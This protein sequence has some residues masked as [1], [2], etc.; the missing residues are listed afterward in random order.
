MITALTAAV[1]ESES[2]E[3]GTTGESLKGTSGESPGVSVGVYVMV[4]VIL[5]V[6]FGFYLHKWLEHARTFLRKRCQK[7]NCETQTDIESQH[8][9]PFL[10]MAPSAPPMTEMAGP[11]LRAPLRSG[12]G[13]MG[14]GAIWVL[15]TERAKCYHV[16][17]DCRALLS[18][19]ATPRRYTKCSKC[20]T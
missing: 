13:N 7:K 15:E 17:S 5:A 11:V 12:T 3:A 10:D 2:M 4:M 1:A 19:F 8:D 6:V 20:G 9:S 18:S 14:V 16:T